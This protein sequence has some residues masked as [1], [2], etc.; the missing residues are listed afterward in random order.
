MLETR[1][2]PKLRARVPRVLE[3]ILPWCLPVKK[4]ETH[5]L[6]T[7]SGIYLALEKTYLY[8]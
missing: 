5:L 8:S 6:K 2:G 1:Q 7:L 3:H 4:D